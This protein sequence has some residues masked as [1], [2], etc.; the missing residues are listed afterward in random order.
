LLLL[1]LI[2]VFLFSDQPIL[3]AAALDVVGR[4]VTTTA[5]GFVSFSR[6]ALSAPSPVIAGWFYRPEAPQRFFIT[7]RPSLPSRHVCSGLS[8][9]ARR[10][11]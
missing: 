9:Y 8:P 5:I 2:G 6:L 3:T 7:L 10:V 11:M 1:L 4:L